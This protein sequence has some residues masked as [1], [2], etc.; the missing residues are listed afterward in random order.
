MFFL[1]VSVSTPSPGRV[2]VVG[3][4]VLQA[5]RRSFWMSSEA[6]PNCL[7]GTSPILPGMYFGLLLAA[8]KNIFWGP[9]AN[10]VQMWLS[11]SPLVSSRRADWFVVHLG[12]EFWSET[13][14]CR[15]AHPNTQV[16][17]VL[18]R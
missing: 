2:V 4:G 12:A 17:S 3:G 8:V 11:V 1:Q 14:F 7:G 6:M 5:A 15:I 9:S 10:L 16:P 18:F 13:C